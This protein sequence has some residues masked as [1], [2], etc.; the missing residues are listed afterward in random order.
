MLRLVVLMLVG[1]STDAGVDES[2]G[3]KVRDAAQRDRAICSAMKRGL[4]ADGHESVDKWKGDEPCRVNHV[5]TSTG[6]GGGA[7]FIVFFGEKWSDDFA[8]PGKALGHFVVLDATGRL[9]P[10]FSNANALKRG[11]VVLEQPAPLPALI[12]Q[13]LAVGAGCDSSAETGRLPPIR[14]I[15]VVSLAAPESPVLSLIAG[16]K[17]TSYEVKSKG[18]II[19]G[20]CMGDVCT[21][22]MGP[23]TEVHTRYPW[24]W[25]AS[26][27]ANGTR[28]EIGPL[29]ARGPNRRASFVWDAQAQA[30]S[31]P[32]GSAS[33][34]FIRFDRSKDPRTSE[35]FAVAIGATPASCLTPTSP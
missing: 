9:L 29:D 19:P 15:H 1:G 28:V 5:I 20:R 21:A 31:G 22:P 11:D 30:F 17:G 18:P 14:E 34:Q 3:A 24:T 4:G 35:K 25:R 23:I 6:P 26:T 13:E 10:W 33:E 8:K 2:F 12:A 27:N 32:D 7:A 16:P